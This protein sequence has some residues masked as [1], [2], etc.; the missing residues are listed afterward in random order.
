MAFDLDSRRFVRN[1]LPPLAGKTALTLGRMTD[2]TGKVNFTNRGFAESELAGATVESL[3][4][5]SAESPTHVHDLNLP[6]DLG[7]QYD[8]IWDC[9]T[10][11]HV[12]DFPQAMRT[13]TQHLAPGGYFVAQ[14]NLNLIGHGFYSIAPETFYKWA[15]VNGYESIRCFVY[16]QRIFRGWREIHFTDDK[17]VEFFLFTPARYFFMCQRP[18]QRSSIPQ[19]AGPSLT[20]PWKFWLWETSLSRHGRL[21]KP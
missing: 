1:Y 12:Y 11:E 17:R 4:V 7:R 14:Q 20:P 8:L 18:G 19:Q 13:V 5:S 10:L 21:Q 2:C 3:D 6:C 9:G 15:R 16:R